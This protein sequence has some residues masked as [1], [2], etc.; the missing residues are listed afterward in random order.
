MCYM[1]TTGYVTVVRNTLGNTLQKSLGENLAG[2][3]NNEVVAYDA[4][5]RQ[6]AEKILTN[7]ID[8]PRHVEYAKSG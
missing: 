3:D 5:T 4:Q 7:E 8:Q 1:C 6:H 2:I